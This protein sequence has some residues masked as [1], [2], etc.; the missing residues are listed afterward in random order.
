MKRLFV[1]AAALAAGLVCLTAYAG[2]P[3]SFEDLSAS[4]LRAMEKRANDLHIK[5]V[6]V[7]AFAEGAELSA[8]SSKMRVFGA[9]TKEGK[10]PEPRANL[11]A[12]AYSKAC[13]M[14]ETGK[15]SGQAGRAVYAGETG[16]EGGVTKRT[17][18]G[19]VFAAFSGGPSEDDV[20]ISLAGLAVLERL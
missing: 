9:L 10:A 4:A 8:W 15:P 11:L 1:P 18:R 19:F 7:V 6:G 16:W 12:I 20:K 13:E 2:K 14:A 3:A 5:G 17:K